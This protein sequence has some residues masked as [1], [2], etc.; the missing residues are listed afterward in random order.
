MAIASR[1]CGILAGCRGSPGEAWSE[2]AA[3]SEAKEEKIYGY[4]FQEGRSVRVGGFV[5]TSLG[6]CG[7]ATNDKLI[8]RDLE[9]PQYRLINPVLEKPKTLSKSC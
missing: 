9:K 2:Q 1:S 4:R 5:G 6:P 7:T 3:N 8:N